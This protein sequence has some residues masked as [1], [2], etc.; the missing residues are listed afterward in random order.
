MAS[1]TL[2]PSLD[3]DLGLEL[4]LDLG[5][6]PRLY[7]GL[8]LGFDLGNSPPPL[9]AFPMLLWLQW[10]AFFGSQP[11]AAVVLGGFDSENV[12]VAAVGC[13]LARR[14]SLWLQWRAF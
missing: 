2:D 1:K 12:T 4:V 14:M 6:D 7:L 8:D 11:V 13:V 3:L 10:G 5:L 9:R